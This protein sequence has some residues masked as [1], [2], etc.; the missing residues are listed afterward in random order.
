MECFSLPRLFRAN[1]SP[2][3]DLQPCVDV[4]WKMETEAIFEI[5]QYSLH[6]H[7]VIT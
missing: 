3:F 5:W 1:V 2:G 7:G 6:L 4:G